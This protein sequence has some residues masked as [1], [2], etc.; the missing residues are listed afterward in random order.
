M[1]DNDILIRGKHA[2][3]LKFLSE[4]TKL[5]GDSY[6]KNGAGVFK[7]YID[8]LLVAPLIGA[9]QNKR[10][11]E[12]KTTD[13][14]ANILAAAVV[15]EQGNL[16]F[17]YRLVM[18]TDTSKKL[19]P[20]NQ[21]DF[22]FR[23]NGDM[24]LFMQYVRGGIEYLYEYFTDSATTKDDYYDKIITLIKDIELEANDNY[25]EIINKTIL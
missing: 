8:V 22:V 16:M 11:D 5:L 1:F 7:R 3:Y 17:V 15:K 21:I 18:L 6:A 13:D 20:D 23:E 9:I 25:D 10:A 24:D 14:R 19:D 4:K 12:D 2:T